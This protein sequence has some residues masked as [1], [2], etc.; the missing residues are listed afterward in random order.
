[1]TNNFNNLLFVKLNYNKKTP[2]NKNYHLKPCFYKDIDFNFINCGLLT[3]QNNIFCLDIDEKDDG[4]KEWMTTYLNKHEEPNTLKEATPSG[5]YHYYFLETDPTYNEEENELI[6]RITQKSKYRNKGIDIIRNFKNYAVFNGSTFNGKKYKLVNDTA[7]QKIPL[8][9]IKWILEKEKPKKEGLNNNLIIMTD[10]EQLKNLLENFKE[11]DNKEWH[12]ITAGIK[13]LLE[14]NNLDKKKIK[15]IWDNWSKKYDINKEYDKEKNYK[16]WDSIE[17]NV[18]LNY[19]INEY[20]S[21]VSKKEKLELYESFKPLE[22]VKIP[23]DMKQYD[24]NNKFL[25]DENSK[26]R[27]FSEKIF[28]KY[29]TIII[30]STTG[31]GKTTAVSKFITSFLKNNKEQVEKNKKKNIEDNKKEEETEKRP[32]ILYKFLSLVSL[33]TLAKQHLKNFNNINIKHYL[34][35]KEYLNKDSDNLVICLNSLMMFNDYDGEYFKNYIVYIDE[36]NSFLYSLTHNKQLEPILNF[37]INILFKIINNCHKIILSDA[38]INENVFN[39]VSGRT[40]KI[41]INNEYKKYEGVKCFFLNDENEFQKQFLK[42]VNN[43][44]YFF[45]GCDSAKIATTYSFLIQDKPKILITA[46]EPFNIYDATEQFKNNFVIAS[47]SILTGIDFS[48]E[49]PQ[50]VFIY[51]NGLTITPE[52]VFQQMTRTRNIKNIYI[53]TTERKN[54]SGQYNILNEVITE[55]EEAG[56]TNIYYKDIIDEQDKKYFELFCFN[57]YQGDTFETNKK[58]HLKNI[59]VN[60]GFIIEEI[61]QNKKLDKATAKEQK[62]KYEEEQEIKFNKHIDGE[63]NEIYKEQEKFLGLQ[64]KEDKIKYKEATTDKYKRADYCNLIRLLYTDDKIKAKIKQQNE[65][66]P[67]YKTIFC[68]FYKI[69]LIYELE[70]V[71]NFE[72]FDFDK[73]EIDEP[74]KIDSNLLKNINTSFRCTGKPPSTYNEFKDF[75]EKKISNITGHLEI[76]DT[77]RTQKNGIKQRHHKINTEKLNHYLKLTEFKNPDR[78]DLIN[79]PLFYKKEI[80]KDDNEGYHSE[81]IDDVE[82]LEN[83]K[84]ADIIEILEDYRTSDK[85]RETVF[86]IFH[87]FHNTFNDNDLIKIGLSI[88]FIKNY[89]ENIKK[90]V[91]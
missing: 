32:T 76:I 2:I 43:D 45:M 68:P 16:I 49:T 91:K 90:Y 67:N 27:Q 15:K 82:I 54:K 53:Y 39:F 40:N 47:P 75:Y 38:V 81:F 57:E 12:Q 69:G 60:N 59:L 48:I 33:K 65:R 46:N 24:M 8:T 11:T 55:K 31:T 22:A 35:D 41:Y 87:K 58:Q 71:L 56:K 28:N 72:R 70:R 18:N 14:F 78:I 89:R 74:L 52:Q 4:L 50:D 10:E 9:L 20:N 29:E 21:K 6:K 37:I 13:N 17:R 66:T 64:T 34:D 63:E 51:M 73:K 86:N 19:I 84:E 25:N 77:T 7:P 79:S 26:E 23:D 1:M 36:I 85:Q 62:E 83:N 88:E 42:N 5:G 3:S 80:K 30:K 61:G 44:E